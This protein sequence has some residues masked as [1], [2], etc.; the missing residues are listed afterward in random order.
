MIVNGVRAGKTYLATEDKKELLRALYDVTNEA[1][2]HFTEAGNSMASVLEDG[3]D[4]IITTISF[5]QVAEQVVIP[6]LAGKYPWLTRN[7]TVKLLKYMNKNIKE[8]MKQIPTPDDA[9]LGG[10][11]V[12]TDKTL[13]KYYEDLAKENKH[14]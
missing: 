12:F 1:H 13:T 8:W 4:Y 11:L 5:P 9:L 14:E 6:A 10:R 2:V 7:N 3:S